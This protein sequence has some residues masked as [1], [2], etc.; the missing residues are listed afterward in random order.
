MHSNHRKSIL[1]TYCPSPPYSSIGYPLHRHAGWIANLQQEAHAAVH[2][3]MKNSLSSMAHSRR[4]F[5]EP[6]HQD[7]SLPSVHYFSSRNSR[8]PIMSTDQILWPNYYHPGERPNPSEQELSSSYLELEN[9]T[10]VGKSNMF[11]EWRG[12]INTEG[13]ARN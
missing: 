10:N 9:E 2:D 4:P 6:G 12:I 1:S 5:P 7:H 11:C 8:R 13:L 3:Q